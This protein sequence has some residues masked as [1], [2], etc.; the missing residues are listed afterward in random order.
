MKPSPPLFNSSH[1]ESDWRQLH[2]NVSKLS[3]YHFERLGFTD[4]AN[5]PPVNEIAAVKVSRP[6]Y[7]NVQRF[8]RALF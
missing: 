8:W 1:Q 3:V 2:A 5:V 6:L 4:V 7:E